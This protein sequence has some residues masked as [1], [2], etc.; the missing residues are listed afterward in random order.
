MDHYQYGKSHSLNDE[1]QARDCTICDPLWENR[2]YRIHQNTDIS[3]LSS[4]R[5]TIC[6]AALGKYAMHWQV[7]AV[8]VLALPRAQKE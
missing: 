8:S 7:I 1:Q 3:A 5:A 4:P 6:G 2:P